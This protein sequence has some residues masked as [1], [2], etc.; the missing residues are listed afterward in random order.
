MYANNTL[1]CCT[2]YCCYYYYYYLL[3]PLLLWYR[4]YYTTTNAAP[5]AH[6]YSFTHVIEGFFYCQMS[7][8]LSQLLGYVC[9][10]RYEY[11]F[12]ADSLSYNMKLFIGR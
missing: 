10:V 5:P 8:E 4:C 1:H 3:L 7:I 11:S 12:V 6:V 2:H 9:L